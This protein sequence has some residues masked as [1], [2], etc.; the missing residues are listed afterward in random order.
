MITTNQTLLGND[1]VAEMREWLITFHIRSF[2][3]KW[4]VFGDDMNTPLLL[5]LFTLGSVQ[6]ER[7]QTNRRHS[8]ARN[9]PPCRRRETRTKLAKNR[10]L[11][12]SGMGQDQASAPRVSIS[13]LFIDIFEVSSKLTR[14]YCVLLRNI[15]S[16]CRSV[17]LLWLTCLS[18]PDVT[19]WRD[20]GG[21]GLAPT[22]AGEGVAEGG[23]GGVMGIE[24]AAGG[25]L[26]PS[27]LPQPGVGPQFP[28]YRG[29]LPP[30]VSTKNCTTF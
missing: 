1:C 12:I 19:S 29:I 30:F 9:F 17:S 2:M 16:E 4:R 14:S 3:N 22:M 26:L 27:P 24:G 6:V 18:D 21:R 23:V 5:W 10:P 25:A 11:Q 8:L 28:P 13:R 7:D 15:L 20:G